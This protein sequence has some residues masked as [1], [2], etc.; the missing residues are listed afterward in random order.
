ME[1]SMLILSAPSKIVLKQ[2]R[3]E[4]S[5]IQEFWALVVAL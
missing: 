1:I 4:I 3:F 5:K 2:W